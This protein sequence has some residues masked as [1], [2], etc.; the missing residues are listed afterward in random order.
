MYNNSTM[1]SPNYSYNSGMMS[2]QQQQQMA[3]Y[4]QG[5]IPNNVPATTPM[6]GLHAVTNAIVNGLLQNKSLQGMN[7]QNSSTNGVAGGNAMGGNNTMGNNIF[8]GLFGANPNMNAPS[9]PL[10]LSGATPP[11]QPSWDSSNDI[12]QIGS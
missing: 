8:S 6:S 9:S 10:Q 2:P 12:N 11:T 4:A 7:G 1:M 5:L 3:Y